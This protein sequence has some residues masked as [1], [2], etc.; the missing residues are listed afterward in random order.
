MLTTSPH[1]ET[2]HLARHT[3]RKFLLGGKKR[4]EKEEMFEKLL[5]NFKILFW[6]KDKLIEEIFEE[7]ISIV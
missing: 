2:R 3:G 7:N 4:R 5:L 6:N 1:P